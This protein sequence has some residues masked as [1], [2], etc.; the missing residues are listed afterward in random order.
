MDKTI[1]ELAK[2]AND[3]RV[4]FVE[5]D[6][7]VRNEVTDLLDSFF[8]TVDNAANG[9]EGLEKYK[10]NNSIP[11]DRSVK[12]AKGGRK[13]I[14][15]D[16]VISDIRMPVMNGI[17]MVKEIRKIDKE[18]P[19]IMVSAH[20]EPEY[21]IE[22]INADIDKFILKPIENQRFLSILLYVCKTIINERELFKSRSNL[23]A[24]FKSIKDAIITVDS[25]LRVT[26]LNKAAEEICGF[27]G[28]DKAKGKKY[29]SFLS[30]CSGECLDTLND[31]INTKLPT[32][33]SR[34]EC[35]NQ[36]GPKRVASLITYPLFNAQE[37]FDGC[38][39]VVR[40]ETRLI[41]LESDLHERQRFYNIIGKS[42]KLQKIYTFIEALADTQTTVLITGENGTGKGLVAEA[43]HH[44]SK[45]KEGPFVVINCTALSD[46]L[47]ESEL[48]GHVKGA[49]TG[50]V[51][52]RVGRFQKADGGTIF[53][54]EIGDITNTMQLRLLRVLQEMEFE[55]V[56]DSTPIK[57]DVRVVAAT[58]QDIR[59]KVRLGKFREDLYHRLKVVEITIPP[60]RDRRD[61]IPFL[62]DH[63]IENLNKKH[64][65][66]IKSL[67]ADTQKIFMDYGWPGN[68][69][70]L[71][72]T[73]EHAFVLSNKPI[74][75]VDCLPAD[76]VKTGNVNVRSLESKKLSDR[77]SIIQALKKTDW[78]KAKAA[79][80]LGI[81][82]MTIYHKLKEYDI[83]EDQEA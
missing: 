57:V 53:L 32:E 39:L 29:K 12:L 13:R 27:P 60:L 35:N 55:R 34:F 20:D 7:G 70:E 4:L 44:H 16:I 15:Y 61:D 18:Q 30:G 36:C 67:S 10:H 59:K 78:N 51:S 56:G 79:R 1:K 8:G 3:L 17:E 82:R 83:T 47:L 73:L 80:L 50:A 62:I 72:H 66:N 64:N 14:C 48:F 26:A 71:Q 11:A 37:E 65:K 43:L 24:I 28:I 40:D 33:K 54:D 52:D 5:D 2:Y 69:R 63:F 25:E 31:T 21:L 76:F 6:E 68:V 46:N 77:Q 22:L 45:A 58:N 49:Y 9:Q 42:R 23:D 74:I 81:S 75:T 19:I 38:V 41:E